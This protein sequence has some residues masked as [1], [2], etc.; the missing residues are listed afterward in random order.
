MNHPQQHDLTVGQVAIFYHRGLLHFGFVA[1][2][3]HTK[4]TLIDTASEAIALSPSR[5]II[6]SDQFVANDPDQLAD[7]KQQALQLSETFQPISISGE[8][9]Q[10]L[11]DKHQIADDLKRF[12][13]YLHLKN[14]PEYYYQKHDRFFS[15]N[16][17]ESKLYLESRS[18]ELMRKDYLQRVERYIAYSAF[19]NNGSILDAPDAQN[20]IL[21]LR[22]ILQGNRKEDL[23]KLLIQHSEDGNPIPLAIRLRKSLRDFSDDPALDTSGLP[24]SFLYCA[25]SISLSMPTLPLASHTAFSIDDDDTVDYDDAISLQSTDIGYRLGI[26]VSNLAQVIDAGSLLFAEAMERVSSLYLPSVKVPMLPPRFSEN[27]LSLRS[28]GARAVLSLY[29]NVDQEFAITD[30]ELKQEMIVIERNLSYTQV[31]K[32]SHEEV[33]RNLLRITAKLREQ[34]DI[35]GDKERFY[36]TLKASPDR[37]LIK[38]VDTQSPARMMIEELMILYNR[39][40]ATYATRKNLPLLYRNINQFLDE[41]KEVR[42]SSAFLA[43]SP[44][45]HP[46]IGAEAYLHATS[47]IRR[48]VD[49]INQMQVCSM[50]TED[51]GRFDEPEL[52]GM[53]PPIEKRILQIKETVMRSERYWFLKYIEQE[54]LN[55]P[56]QAVLKGYVNG[57]LKAE[58][59]PWGKQ[60]LLDTPA[61]PQ[62]SYFHVVVY[63]VDWDRRILKADLIG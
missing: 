20:L 35:S 9:F 32:S 2:V 27:E 33:Y 12:A 62:D 24:I 21:E 46:G 1:E 23:E 26:H 52:L 4:I 40:I 11:C 45:Y 63:A 61:K 30:S 60:V 48:V 15:R 16:A 41:N 18:R 42:N 25:E 3:S 57:K 50:L 5:I 39:S 29:L 22:Q 51:K 47:P 31:D 8:S 38:R 34:R 58:I 19:S 14:H 54:Q 6:A 17:D 59:L 43:T 28:D 44:G 49:L 55:N 37:V 36:Y 56:L 7:F 53:I 13:L 10:E